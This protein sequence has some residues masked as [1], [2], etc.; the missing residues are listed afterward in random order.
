MTRPEIDRLFAGLSKKQKLALARR[1]AREI[2][3]VL[4]DAHGHRMYDR[5]AS[6]VLFVLCDRYARKVSAS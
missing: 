5:A 3:H 6:D 1:D 2:A 4:N